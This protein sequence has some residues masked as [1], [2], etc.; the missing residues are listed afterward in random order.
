MRKVGIIFLGNPKK[1][2]SGNMYY[3]GKLDDSEETLM[4]FIN[5]SKGGAKYLSLL[6]FPKD[7]N[8][9]KKEETKNKEEIIDPNELPF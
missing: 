4:A 8:Y 7:D 6:A 5:E 1:S 3:T 9:Q 2:N